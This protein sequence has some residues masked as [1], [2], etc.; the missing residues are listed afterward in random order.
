MNLMHRQVYFIMKICK[1]LYFVCIKV[2]WLN[3]RPQN[4][5]AQ[6]QSGTGKTAA[7]VLTMLSRVDTSKNYPQVGS[8]L[9]Y[10]SKIEL[11]AVFF[12]QLY[13]VICHLIRSFDQVNLLEEIMYSDKCIG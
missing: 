1:S 3:F 11:I 12:S 9:L 5:I 13:R 6:S 7:F 2:I 4:L 10:V 8:I